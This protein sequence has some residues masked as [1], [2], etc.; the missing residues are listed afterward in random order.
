MKRRVLALMMASIMSIGLLAGCSQ[1]AEEK[2]EETNA[3]ES[4]GG[5][6]TV[7]KVA[8][9][10]SAYGA[11]VW[12]DIV[13]A[14]EEV[15]GGEVEVELTIDK[16]IEAKI[17]PQM[18][19]GDFPDVIML[20]L[21]R[22]AGLTETL[23]REDVVE[24]I[25]DAF[26][27]TIPG[28]DMTPNDKVIN[29][30]TDTAALR[31]ADGSELMLAP[32]FYSPTGLWYNKALFEANGYEVPTTWDEMWA[33]GDKAKAD[34]I[35]LFTYPTAG[36]LDG[37]TYSLMYNIG[38]SEFAKAMMSY[39][40]AAWDSED[41]NT[42]FEI[43]NKL[44]EYIEPTTLGNANNQNYLKN[45][46][47]ILDNKALF[48]PNGNWVV[49]EMAEA[50]RAEGFEWG[51]AAV[52]VVEEGADQY[53]YTFLEQIFVPSQAE[54]KELAKEFVA[55]MYSDKAAEIF[56][57]VHAAQ[58]INGVTDVLLE[59]DKTN[60]SILDGKSAATGG[61]VT[62]SSVEGVNINDIVFAGYD[63]VASGS[64]SLED[65]KASVKDAVTK[66]GGAE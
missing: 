5:E 15:K 36:Y 43:M 16:E 50:P 37:F 41:A 3:E 14:F 45:Q 51:L 2:T 53:V 42:Y 39:D 66:L 24:P 60:Y 29:G 61:F 35:S 44:T 57:S 27:M 54:N 38:G 9:L 4:A 13:S 8:A 11:Q 58:P 30:F 55:F 32:M 25:T 47:L 31:N 28:E 12:E 21:G 34:G 26:E 52:P 22:E 7:L 49:G 33:L 1:P 65:W 17:D 63:A 18:K 56:A 62:V 10:E 19:S 48:M 6:K 46:Q 59:E 40:A 20:S 23:L 64:T